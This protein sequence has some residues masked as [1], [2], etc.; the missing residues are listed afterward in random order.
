MS[1]LDRLPVARLSH[2]QRDVTSQNRGELASGGGTAME[3]DTD[4]PGE[5]GRQ[6]AQNTD[7]SLDAACRTAERE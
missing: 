7:Q 4:G 3:R 6:M 2:R 1:R 5:I